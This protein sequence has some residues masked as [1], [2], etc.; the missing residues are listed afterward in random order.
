MESSLRGSGVKRKKITAVVPIRKGSRRVKNKNFKSFAN[1]NLLKLKLEVLKQVD[2]ID[3]II[4][5]TD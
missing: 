3:D 1:S 2:I 5:N 4:V